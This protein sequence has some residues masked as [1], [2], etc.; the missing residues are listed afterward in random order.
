MILAKAVL[1]HV[2]AAL[3]LAKEVAVQIV[4]ANA[5]PHAMI[6]VKMDARVLVKEIVLAHV[7]ADALDV[8]PPAKDVLEV[9]VI[10]VQATVDLVVLVVVYILVIT[11]GFYDRRIY[12]CP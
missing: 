10:T 7:V 6:H 2:A 4:Q 12:I 3:E 9:V 11:V 8:I 5:I 1:D